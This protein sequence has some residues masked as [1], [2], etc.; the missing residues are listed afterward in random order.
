MFEDTDEIS[1]HRIPA[2]H[3]PLERLEDADCKVFV[4]CKVVA[5]RSF[6][7]PHFRTAVRAPCGPPRDL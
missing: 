5:F 2:E 6:R 1:G 7:S 4:D 3:L